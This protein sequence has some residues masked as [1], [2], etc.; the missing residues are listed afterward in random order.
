MC[1]LAKRVSGVAYGGFAARRSR[2]CRLAG[3]RPVV[4]RQQLLTSRAVGVRRAESL[5]AGALS[6]DLTTAAGCIA[7]C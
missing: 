4:A 3:K 6:P 7:W 1:R 5:I 2:W